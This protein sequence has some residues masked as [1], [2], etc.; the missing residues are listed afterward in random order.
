M[1]IIICLLLWTSLSLAQ[2]ITAVNPSPDISKGVEVKLTYD[3]GSYRTPSKILWYCNAFDT[4]TNRY[5]FE[6]F[7]WPHKEYSCTYK[8][9]GT[10]TA[11]IITLDEHGKGVSTANIVIKINNLVEI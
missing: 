5:I 8:K 7:R 3:H 1:K 4:A 10:Y 9:P 6:A 11:N 2:S